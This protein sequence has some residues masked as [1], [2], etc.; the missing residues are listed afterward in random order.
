MKTL[1][2]QKIPD[3]LPAGGAK[4]AISRGRQVLTTRTAPLGE[5]KA[6]YCAETINEGRAWRD[7]SVITSDKADIDLGDGCL[8]ARKNKHLWY[9]CRH[10]RL[11]TS[12]FA[13][14]VY[15]SHNGGKK[16]A[17][18]STVATSTG[19]ARGLWS[20]FLLE[21]ANGEVWCFYDDEDTPARAGFARHQWLMA[22]RWDEKKTTWEDAV[23]VSRAFDTKHLSR[24]GMGSVVEMPDGELICAL[25]S[26]QTSAPHAANIRLVSS[27]NKG[28]SWSHTFRERSV[29]YQPK[30][31]GYSAYSPWLTLLPSGDL[32]CVFATNEDQATP[33]APGTPAHLLHNDIKVVR[34]N[35]R[36][37]TWSTPVTLYAETH[38]AYMPQ[39]LA[40]S[41]KVGFCLLLDAQRS[42]YRN[43]LFNVPK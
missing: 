23:I 3:I 21:K 22:R 42:E 29:I 32:L 7:I 16:W 35:N 38:R 10:N 36:G 31:T 19:K 9:S 2:D 37:R 6:V 28:K 30:R 14:E 20:S 26:V 12:E 27:L 39:V 43:L 5:L 4:G 11:S 34:S 8:L 15:H 40:L 13:I 18:H 17:K 25:E 33:D 24:D 41:D 1:F